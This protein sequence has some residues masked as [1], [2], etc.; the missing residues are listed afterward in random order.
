MA[1]LL[2]K[3]GV[4]WKL[5][6]SQAVNFLLILLI[7]RLTI[8]KPLVKLLNERRRK[9]DQGLKDS[10]R[11]A[12]TLKNV[13]KLKDEELAKAADES[14]KIIGKAE[15]SA[16]VRETELI[17]L[18][19]HKEVEIIENAEKVAKAKTLEAGVE[20]QKGAASLIRSAIAKAVS[21]KPEAID[22]ALVNEAVKNLKG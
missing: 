5:F 13:E 2:E 11:A 16:K 1:E 17:N 15:A 19:K 22:E 21:V 14:V 6:L 18:A 4:N 10:E 7:L 8:Y 3:L 20:F 12:E 9:I